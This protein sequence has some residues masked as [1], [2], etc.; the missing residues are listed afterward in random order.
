MEFSSELSPPQSR[1]VLQQAIHYRT[2][3][4]IEPRG[5]P[6]GETL[7]GVLCGDQEDLLIVEIAAPDEHRLLDGLVGM[8]LDVQMQLGQTQY[9]CDTHVVDMDSSDAGVVLFLA[10][11]PVLHLTQR[12]RFCRVTFRQRCQVHLE[13]PDD[14]CPKPITG[15][16]LNL[17]VDGLACRVDQLRA[18]SLKI[19]DRLHVAF[20]PAQAELGFLF[21]AILRNKTEAGTLGRLIL[22]VQFLVKENDAD[23]QSIRRR[24]SDFLY[25]SPQSAAVREPSV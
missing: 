12:R 5:W 7:T 8:H 15:E 21:E 9:V 25:A 20:Q 4:I 17:S 11:P 2:E 10:R 14:P 13:R 16:L 6:L 24:L 3:L 23:G 19:G 1:R 18:G 22:G